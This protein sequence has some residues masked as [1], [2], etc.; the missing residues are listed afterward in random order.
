MIA[1]GWENLIGRLDGPMW[2]RILIQPTV[3]MFFAIRAGISDARYNKPTFLGCA[4]SNPRSWGLRM[5][6]TW[7]D[8][9]TVFILALI[10]DS[11]Y[12]VIV[13]KFIY[14]LELLITATCLALIPYMI[15][16]DLSSR[17]ARRIGVTKSTDPSLA[18][19][20]DTQP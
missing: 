20:K 5:R 6:E 13:Q 3:A 11:I 1:R 4:F 2:F 19:D 9:G 14:P 15:M 12:Q 7:K 17:V 16:R 10:L 18:I 8:V